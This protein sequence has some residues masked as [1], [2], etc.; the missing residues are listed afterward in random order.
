MMKL[1]KSA[2]S[3][4]LQSPRCEDYNVALF[5]FELFFILVVGSTGNVYNFQR[6]LVATC[7][8]MCSNLFLRWNL[9]QSCVLYPR[10]VDS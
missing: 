8:I 10:V 1:K 7:K 2:L 3:L 6:V 9:G 4:C 5:R